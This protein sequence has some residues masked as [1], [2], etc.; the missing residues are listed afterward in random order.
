[1][2]W[3]KDLYRLQFI[4]RYSNIP[5]V[6]DE[7]VAQHSFFVA[8]IALELM[9]ELEHTWDREKVLTMAITHDWAEA[10][11][12]DVA[13]DVKRDY[14][15]VKKALKAA[16]KKA[17]AHYPNSIRDPYRL[18]EDGTTPEAILVKLADT[19]QCV[20]YLESEVNMGNR[21]MEPLLEESKNYVIDIKSRLLSIIKNDIR[22][23]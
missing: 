13:H 4:T 19:I 2:T 22:I 12:D 5:R 10:Y 21:Y 6:R 14:P 7:N 18:Y 17:M 20:Q 11:V 8:T 1:M 16:E 9:E 15:A 3:Y 23:I